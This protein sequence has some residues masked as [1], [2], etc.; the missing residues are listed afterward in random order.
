MHAVDTNTLA[1]WRFD[2]TGYPFADASG[3]GYSLTTAIGTPPTRY[4]GRWAWGARGQNAGGAVSGDATHGSSSAAVAAFQGDTTI[5]GWSFI[6]QTLSVAA[7][8]V[9]LSDTA[10]SNRAFYVQI[11]TSGWLTAYWKYA[12]NT[13]T[14]TYTQSV[15]AKL[16]SGDWHHWAV[17]RTQTTVATLKMY[18]DGVL[19]QTFTNCPRATAGDYSG[20]VFF[21]GA[22]FNGLSGVLDDVR[23]SKVG[24]SASEIAASAGVAPAS[25]SLTVNQTAYLR[26]VGASTRTL[27]AGVLTTANAVARMRALAVGRGRRG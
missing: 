1:L 26:S 11:A 21:V 15:G 2:E 7:A 5:E 8:L 16:V 23:V 9:A 13:A 18:V 24:R 10:F 22:Q 14:A 25:S 19:Q 3:N 6:D 17:V 20:S 12:S 27:D 4:V